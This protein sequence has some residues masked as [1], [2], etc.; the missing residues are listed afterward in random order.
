M[1]QSDVFFAPIIFLRSLRSHCSTVGPNLTLAIENYLRSSDQS[2]TRQTTTDYLRPLFSSDASSP[3]ARIF[4]RFSIRP[5]D[6]PISRA[7]GR[8]LYNT[9]QRVIWLKLGPLRS[10]IS[11]YTVNFLRLRNFL[12]SAAIS[13]RFL[14]MF[15]TL[16]RPAIPSDSQNRD[17]PNRRGS[18]TTRYR[19]NVG[20]AGE[21]QSV[22]S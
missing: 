9:K 10:N 7:M 15:K 13:H 1:V 20:D 16:R 5:S 18:H 12:R 17:R 21:S 11:H 4:I 8:R 19:Y 22:P 6:P 2:L 3:T 14:N